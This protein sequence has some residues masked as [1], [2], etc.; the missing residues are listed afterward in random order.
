MYIDPDTELVYWSCNQYL[1]YFV[2]LAILRVVVI[3]SF[4][5]ITLV[6]MVFPQTYNQPTTQ[7]RYSY[8]W[9]LANDLPDWRNKPTKSTFLFKKIV[10]TLKTG[11]YSAPSSFNRVFISPIKHGFVSSV[12]L[13]GLRASYTWGKVTY[14]TT[15]VST[16]GG[17]PPRRLNK[18]TPKIAILI[19][20]LKICCMVC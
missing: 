14:G 12:C 17:N 6:F 15:L 13:D 18:P 3:N 9:K 16:V 2:L 10:K 20:D 19:F 7:G 1:Y 8:W 4:Y 11:C 5:Y